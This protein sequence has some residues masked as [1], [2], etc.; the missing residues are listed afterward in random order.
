MAKFSKKDLRGALK[1]R[2]EES[3]NRAESYGSGGGS[4]YDPDKIA[5]VKFWTPKPGERM[6]DI[7]P[8]QAGSQHPDAKEGD[9]VYNVDFWVHYTDSYGPLICP[10]STFSKGHPLHVPGCPYC[11]ERSKLWREDYDRNKSLIDYLRAR[12]RVIYNVIPYGK[13]EESED[14][15]LIWDVA[16]WFMERHLASLARDP[17]TGEDIIFVLPDEEGK[18]I[19]FEIKEEGK[20][21]L[22]FMGHKFL[23]RD[24]SISEELLDQAYTLDELL[25]I[26]S[27]DTLKEAF[28]I[29]MNSPSSFPKDEGERYEE[30]EKPNRGRRIRREESE[31]EEQEEEPKGDFECPAGGEFGEDF[32]EYDE[33]AECPLFDDCADSYEEMKK[34][35]RRARRRRR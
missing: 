32:N 26:P 20:G 28:E 13:D 34:K 10:T 24:Y 8:F 9:W 4:Y 23:D 19:Y 15:V 21:R 27:M 12:R 16:H 3:R 1:K 25:V 29:D 6:V 18:T 14:E 17:R 33:C 22:A 11:T 5:E 35:E 2:I 7:V 31:E 30:E